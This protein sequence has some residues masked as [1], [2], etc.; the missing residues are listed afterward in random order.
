MES[1]VSLWTGATLLNSSFF[2]F[3]GFFLLRNTTN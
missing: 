2:L 1:S 3:N